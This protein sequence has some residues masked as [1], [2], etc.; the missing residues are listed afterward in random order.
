MGFAS[1]Y[2]GAYANLVAENDLVYIGFHNSSGGLNYHGS[3][4]DPLG[5]NPITIGLPSNKTNV[6]IDTSMAKLNWN[7]IEKAKVEGSE[8][9]QGVAVDVNGVDTVNPSDAF[10][11]KSIEGH[12]GT[13]LAYGVEL[14]AGAISNSRVDFSNFGGWGSLYIIIN[15]EFFAGKDKIKEIVANSTDFIK[16]LGDNVY[17][18]GE[19]SSNNTKLNSNEGYIEVSEK[20][21]ENIK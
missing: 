21:L 10:S 9:Q 15:P 7:D 3:K 6:I 4:L 20:L 2:I 12:K 1:G 11:V 16:T 18:P 13:T 17:F 8:L 19:R 14:L 5:T